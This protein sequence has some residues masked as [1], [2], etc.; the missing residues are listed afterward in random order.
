MSARIL[1]LSM[2]AAAVAIFASFLMAGVSRADIYEYD[3]ARRLARVTYSTGQV[4]DYTYDGNSNLTAVIV[5]I[6]TGVPSGEAPRFVNALRVGQPNPTAG[7]A[8]LRF[9]LA[10][11]GKTT[12]RLF[13]VSGRLVRTVFDRVYPPGEYEARVSLSDMP[14]GVYFYRLEAP[15][16]RASRRL[17]LLK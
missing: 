10:R 11:E 6:S 8:R 3:F 9:S 7:E 5:S 4:V 14:A 2:R 1:S 16:F 15:A 12:L 13:D 17:V